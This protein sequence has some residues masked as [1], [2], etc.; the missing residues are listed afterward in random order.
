MRQYFA[1]IPAAIFGVIGK[2][3]LESAVILGPPDFS[4]Y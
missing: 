2:I 3:T 4:G 1:S